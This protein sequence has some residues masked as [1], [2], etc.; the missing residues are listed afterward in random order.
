MSVKVS[1]Q[2]QTK[3]SHYSLGINSMTESWIERF[4]AGPQLRSRAQTLSIRARRLHRQSTARILR[5]GFGSVLGQTTRK[6]HVASLTPLSIDDGRI[7]SRRQRD[8]PHSLTSSPNAWIRSSIAVE[9]SNY[10]R[11]TK[12]WESGRYEENLPRS[13]AVSSG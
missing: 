1:S 5:I 7:V 3:F 2:V 6:R 8:N 12:A 4:G 9:V 10:R 11:V 13:K